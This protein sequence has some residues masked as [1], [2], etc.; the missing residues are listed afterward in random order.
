MW[1]HTCKNQPR[2]SYI[3]TLRLARQQLCSDCTTQIPTSA[4]AATRAACSNPG[5]LLATHS[6][7]HKSLYVGP[8]HL[9][10]SLGDDISPFPQRHC[11][12]IPIR[13]LP[14]TFNSF[15]MLYIFKQYFQAY[16]C[17]C[18]FISSNKMQHSH[19]KDDCSHGTRHY[20][21]APQSC[22]FLSL[23]Q[24]LFPL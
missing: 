14:T 10:N 21:A 17:I 4:T 15:P 18:I 3:F 16:K 20:S 24:S 11:P 13:A 5:I 6:P 9:F 12:S 23:Q 19:I 7:S 2:L 1:K 22:S 8:E